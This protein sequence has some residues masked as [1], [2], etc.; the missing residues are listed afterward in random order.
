MQNYNF[1]DIGRSFKNKYFT[2]SNKKR[3]FANQNKIIK[4]NITKININNICKYFK[5]C[6]YIAI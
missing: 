1:I 3:N 4:K 6:L 2:K 5:M